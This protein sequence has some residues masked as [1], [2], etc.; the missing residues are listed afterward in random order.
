MWASLAL[1][2]GAASTATI[3]TA[4]ATIATAT[5]TIA[6]AAATIASAAATIA[7]AAATIASAFAAHLR[8]GG[9]LGRT[10]I[11]WSGR[12]VE[13]HRQGR[14]GAQGFDE[15]GLIG[16]GA[17]HHGGGAAQPLHLAATGAQA[18]AVGA[19]SGVIRQA[20]PVEASVTHAGLEA[21]Q[22]A[23]LVDPIPEHALQIAAVGVASQE[24]A[25]GV[26]DQSQRVTEG[27]GALGVE[28]RERRGILGDEDEAAL[29]EAQLDAREELQ[30]LGGEGGS[31]GIEI[32][33][34]GRGHGGAIQASV[35]HGLGQCFW[36]F[37][38]RHHV[39]VDEQ[40]TS[41][42][43]QEGQ[44]VADPPGNCTVNARRVLAT[45]P[46]AG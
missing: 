25:G 46:F 1:A 39:Q 8:P 14:A 38:A 43:S 11:S 34:A 41:S 29:V 2:P 7:S 26:A 19:P 31:I 28:P 27:E 4:T 17:S 21:G 22:G 5:A 13:L 10:P 35:G 6:S 12:I 45:R 42:R 30:V 15:L 20:I 36:A 32:E 44:S 3:A 24:G 37:A 33:G 40:R 9:G 16:D 23:D 18:R